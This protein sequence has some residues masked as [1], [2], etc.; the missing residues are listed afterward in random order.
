MARQVGK[1]IL[2][3]TKSGCT[4]YIMEGKGYIRRRSSLDEDQWRKDDAFARTRAAAVVFGGSSA[5]VSC[6]W[7]AIPAK[8]KRL[9]DR[10]A[11]NRITTAVR[12]AH[13][14]YGA[15]YVFRTAT[16]NAKPTRR[17]HDRCER[18]AAGQ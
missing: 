6:M 14:T 5:F 17:R 4:G 18:P 1:N 15:D 3:G 16:R 10:G 7:R 2:V 8:M 9:M 12:N 13:L 11:Y